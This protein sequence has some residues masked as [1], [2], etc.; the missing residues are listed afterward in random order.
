MA[1]RTVSHTGESRS[2]IKPRHGNQ[3]ECAGAAV[4]GAGCG[5]ARVF[6]FSWTTLELLEIIRN[7]RAT[8]LPA[9]STE[10]E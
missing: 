7:R 10:P 9:D 2:K 1:G 4:D 3:C 6:P 8:P 5:V